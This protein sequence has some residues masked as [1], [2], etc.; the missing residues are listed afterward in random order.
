MRTGL[1]RGSLLLWLVQLSGGSVHA[2]SLRAVSPLAG[3]TLTL[4]PTPSVLSADGSVWV[5][6]SARTPSM[7]TLG[8]SR[9]VR[10]VGTTVTDLGVLP[11]SQDTLVTATDASGAIAV[12]RCIG[13]VPNRAF[14]YN[15]G[16][17]MIALIPP[18]AGS[19]SNSALGISADGIYI[20]GVATS[21]QNM[22]WVLRAGVYTFASLPVNITA[23]A[24][25]AITAAGEV[26]VGG[27]TV[28]TSQRAFRW[29]PP[30][31]PQLLAL[32]DGYVASAAACISAD[33]SVIAGRASVGVTEVSVVWEGSTPRI[34]PA[35][36]Q[37]DVTSRGVAISA[38][39]TV[40]VGESADSSDDRY[41]WV[42]TPAMGIRRLDEVLFQQGVDASAWALRN[43][44]SI[45]ADGLTI[46]GTGVFTSPQGVPAT[47]AF[48]ANVTT[49]CPTDWN[50][51]GGIDGLD[52]DA[53]FF[54][55]AA[56]IGDMNIDGAVDGSDVQVFFDRW[57]LGLC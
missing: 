56:G 57:V 8:R 36:R 33:G 15:A 43:A 44:G 34:L 29:S 3:D 50:G 32:P 42:Y 39:G 22:W 24:P 30:A 52:V 6:L 20:F 13:G 14:M 12:G 10:V 48:I 21:P 37:Q 38:D 16:T 5:G 4:S 26:I 28:G 55:W 40:I 53:Y 51:D 31:Q 35:L 25:V 7:G 41:V 47:R 1:A 23:L 54:D 11:G 17:G 49:L 18:P 9:G 46:S 27:A 19:I 45:S 2:Q